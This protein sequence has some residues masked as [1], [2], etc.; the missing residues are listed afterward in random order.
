MSSNQTCI[1]VMMA[2]LGVGCGAA[3][4]GASSDVS[5]PIFGGA[6]AAL[7]EIKHQARLLRDGEMLC[8]GTLIAPQW[9]LT[10]AHCLRSDDHTAADYTPCWVISIEWP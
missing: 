2:V 3:E 6:D 4:M 8:G 7:G 10:A 5:E 1:V 9:V